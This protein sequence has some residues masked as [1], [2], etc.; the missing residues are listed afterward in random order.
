VIPTSIPTA[1][2]PPAAPDLTVRR[3]AGT[4]L[5]LFG[6]LIG[7]GIVVGVVWSLIAPTVVFTVVEDGL[8]DTDFQAGRFFIAESLYGVLGAAAGLLA[9]LVARRW[10]REI[11][12]PVV[13]ALALGGVLA[14]VV[15]WRVGIWLGPGAPDATTLALGD[16]TELPLRLRSSGLLLVWPMASL[17]VALVT[18]TLDDHT[19]DS[20][21]VDQVDLEPTPVPEPAG[22]IRART[23]DHAGSTR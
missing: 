14:S 19:G 1:V 6:T 13:V 7:F 3:V 4:V 15:A 10:V 21:R 20:C 22:S 8:R 11:G 12:W 2:D 9:G 17:A 18:A 23:G 5:I 16:V